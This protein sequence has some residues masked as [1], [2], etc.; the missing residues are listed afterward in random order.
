MAMC[1][2]VASSPL[3]AEGAA[4]ALCRALHGPLSVR[5]QVPLENGFV[6]ALQAQ[7]Q[8]PSESWPPRQVQLQLARPGLP[9]LEM[10]VPSASSP[11]QL[12]TL[13]TAARRV[14]EGRADEV[15][16][17]K[18][19][20]AE[21]EVV[22]ECQ[23]RKIA[24]PLS[25]R[26]W[27]HGVC[28]HHALFN[29]RCMLRGDLDAL[30]DEPKFWQQALADMQRLANFGEQSGRWPRSRVLCGVA[31]EVH[32]RHLV[33]HDEELK[34]RITLATSLESLKDQLPGLRKSAVHGFLLGAATHWYSAAVLHTPGGPQI[35]FFDSYNVPLARVRSDAEV[36]DLLER[37]LKVSRNDTVEQ[38][39]RDPFWVHRPSHELELAAEQGVE[40]WWKGVRKASM[41]WRHKPL[42]VRRQLK[43]LDLVGVRDF[44][45]VLL[46]FAS[47]RLE[48]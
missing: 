45:Q 35:Y 26:Q 39:K 15:P 43:R 6:A 37:Q 40:E 1:I 3:G 17:E 25:I 4:E 14:A 42:E 24:Q 5:W 18:I 10:Q 19:L 27:H 8:E 22:D 28:G 2:D 44:L 47:G 31:D 20:E 29:L 41:F 23:E 9:A 32:L 7:L 21:L 13:I 16:P 46:D 33:D 36:E 38:L 34:G 11:Q 48:F 30:R 12:A